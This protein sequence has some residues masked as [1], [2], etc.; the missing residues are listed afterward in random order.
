MFSAWKTGQQKAKASGV[1]SISGSAVFR[2]SISHYRNC[3]SRLQVMRINS[4]KIGNRKRSFFWEAHLNL[5]YLMLLQREV[6]ISKRKSCDEVWNDLATA[7]CLSIELS[8]PF[9]EGRVSDIRPSNCHPPPKKK[10]KRV[11][12]SKKKLTCWNV[13][14]CCF[15][16]V[17]VFWNV[18]SVANTSGKEGGEQIRVTLTWTGARGV[19][20]PLNTEELSASKM[21]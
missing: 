2:I 12:L 11:F 5:L 4:A 1:T 3:N 15:F 16:C 18:L 13:F 8:I 6:I 7:P 21:R 19:S 20:T 17:F 14:F 10:E 9:V